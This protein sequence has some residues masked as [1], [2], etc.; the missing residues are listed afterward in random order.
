VSEI[1]N[2]GHGSLFRNLP[3]EAVNIVGTALGIF[4]TVAAGATISQALPADPS[5]WL[6]AGCYAAPAAAVFAIYW[7]VAQKL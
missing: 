5:P 6:F 7:Y 3:R 2:R 4:V 1:I